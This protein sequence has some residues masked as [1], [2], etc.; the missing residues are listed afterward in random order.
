ML[1]PLV[2]CPLVLPLR[3]V[4]KICVP[5]IWLARVND[6]DGAIEKVTGGFQVS[7]DV[8]GV[9]ARAPSSHIDTSSDA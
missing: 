9:Q 8:V 3:F 1:C 7:C 2:L 4:P 6:I 5:K